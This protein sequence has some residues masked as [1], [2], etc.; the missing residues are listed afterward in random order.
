MKRLFTILFSVLTVG[1]FAQAQT[2]PN[3]IRVK[4]EANLSD[5]NVAGYVV[6]YRQVSSPTYLA[7]NINGVANTTLTLPAVPG[8]MYEMYVVSKNAA[9]LES[10]PSNK[11]RGQNV[12]VNGL[13]KPTPI[14]LLDNSTTNFP[15]FL[16][17]SGGTN[18]TVV[19]TVPNITYTATTTV[20][21]DSLVYKLPETY[22]AASVT[23]YYNIFRAMNNKPIISIP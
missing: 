20:G 6:Y 22:S 17:V 16:M 5:T 14:T 9:G 19:G 13:G 7:T 15:G 18:G 11:I 10:D 8:G 21:R 1:I 3:E 23:N 2:N 4:W 12:L